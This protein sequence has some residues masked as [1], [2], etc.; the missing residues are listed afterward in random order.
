VEER[1]Y[2]DIWKE[3]TYLGN[4]ADGSSLFLKLKLR[5]ACQVMPSDRTGPRCGYTMPK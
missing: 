5:H 4:S 1:L 2:G 3:G